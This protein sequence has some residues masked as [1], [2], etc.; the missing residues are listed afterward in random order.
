MGQDNGE[1][2][3]KVTGNCLSSISMI[4]LRMYRACKFIDKGDIVCSEGYQEFQLDLDQL[5]NWAKEWQME[6]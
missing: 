3:K 6:F 4:W 1:E 5:V 2:Y